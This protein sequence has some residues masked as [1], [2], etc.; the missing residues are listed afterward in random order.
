MVSADGDDVFFKQETDDA[1]T[2]PGKQSLTEKNY[3]IESKNETKTTVNYSIETYLTVKELTI[4]SWESSSSTTALDNDLPVN[5][6]SLE[7][8]ICSVVYSMMTFIDRCP[9][10]VDIFCPILLQELRH[11]TSISALSY[12]VFSCL[13]RSFFSVFTLNVIRKLNDQSF[14]CT[15]ER[16]GGGEDFF[17]P[18][19]SDWSLRS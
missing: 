4:T 18:S 3:V 17:V 12:F 2:H 9:S 19:P 15:Q 11:H 7:S 14:H 16:A 1:V 10:L 5:F 13:S 8:R 6:T